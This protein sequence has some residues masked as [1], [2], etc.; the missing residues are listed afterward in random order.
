[1]SSFVGACSYRSEF[2]PLEEIFTITSRSNRQY[3]IDDSY[4]IDLLDEVFTILQENLNDAELVKRDRY[5]DSYRVRSVTYC[6]SVEDYYKKMD[7]FSINVY[8]T[9]YVETAVSGSGWLVSPESQYA[10]YKIDKEKADKVYQ[11]V[12]NYK[13]AYEKG[14]EDERQE[15]LNKLT[16]EN[17]FASFSNTEHRR[18]VHERR[19]YDEKRHRPYYVNNVFIDNDSL[20]EDIVG[21]GYEEVTSDYGYDNSIRIL[22]TI[23]DGPQ[24]TIMPYSAYLVG[25]YKSKYYET[26]LSVERVYKLNEEKANNLFMKI[27]E[28]IANQDKSI[29]K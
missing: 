14:I 22:L 3:Y 26:F 1:M 25:Y 20:Y 28:L 16:L 10:L 27:D 29:E 12:N 7:Y 2:I 13:I 24:L 5:E 17:F 11:D 23:D 9:G 15:E 6:F 21:L 18:I 8:T 4:N 19:E